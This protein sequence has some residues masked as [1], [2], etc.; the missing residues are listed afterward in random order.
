MTRLIILS[1][2]LIFFIPIFGQSV[3]DTSRQTIP[4]RIIKGDNIKL[5]IDSIRLSV[6]ND[7]LKF[8]TKDLQHINGRTENTN[9]Y[10]LL[11][12][13]DLRYSYRLDIIKGTLVSEFTNEI[14]DASKI[15]GINVLDKKESMG[16]VGAVG[17]NGC[18]IIST[19]R[20]TKLNFKVAGAPLE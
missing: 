4:S 15:E 19:K 2:C 9:S 12:S 13:V 17:N 10:S 8:N 14:L 11:F 6:L 20:K 18:I 3:Q 16:I 5:F 7:T 1:A